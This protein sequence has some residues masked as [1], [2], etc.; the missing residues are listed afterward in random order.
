MKDYMRPTLLLEYEY[1]LPIIY[2]NS[3]LVQVK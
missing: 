3:G 2:A 1:D